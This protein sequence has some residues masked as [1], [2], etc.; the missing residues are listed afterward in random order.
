MSNRKWENKIITLLHSLNIKTGYDIDET[1]RFA[2]S[3]EE[4]ENKISDVYMKY[5]E[6]NIEDSKEDLNYYDNF[7]VGEPDDDVNPSEIT[8][9][10]SQFFKDLHEQEEKRSNTFN[11]SPLEDAVLNWI[12]QLL[13]LNNGEFKIIKAENG[14][15]TIEFKTDEIIENKKIIS[16]TDEFTAEIYKINKNSIVYNKKTSQS[17]KKLKDTGVLNGKSPRSRKPTQEEKKPRT[18]RQN[19]NS[20]NKDTE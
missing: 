2:S 4:L 6:D 12:F 16:L 14:A 9:L 17:E 19:K 3:I 18:P 5:I 1:D 15:I 20:K 7:D 11:G 8:D 10:L 13:L